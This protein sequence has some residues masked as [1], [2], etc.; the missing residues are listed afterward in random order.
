M[1]APAQVKSE[2][3]RRGRNRLTLALTLAGFLVLFG[4]PIC[5]RLFVLEAFKTP[6]GS[7]TP[8]L[9]P[10]DH[11]FVRKLALHARQRTRGEVIVFEYPENRAQDF[12]KRVIAVPGDTFT[13]KDG[14][15]W[16]NGWEVP[17]CS[18]G[19]ASYDDDNDGLGMAPSKHTGELVLE[20]LEGD[21]YLTF[22]DH[23]SGAAPHEVQGPYTVAPGEV[24]VLG[25]NR[26]NSHD[27]RM[28]W[29]SKGGG[30]PFA[31]V[32]GS[33]LVRWFPFSRAGNVSTPTLPESMKSLEPALERCLAGRPPPDKTVPPAQR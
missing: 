23:S 14:H 10:G 21:A 13:V 4:V 5:L 24:W 11:V 22:L 2:Q 17:H 18:L 20:Y 31:L 7:M 12:I 26:M 28:W 29:S 32:R 30:V 9:I 3:T 6:S 15:P 27:S 33:A 25:D 19:E 16:I 1:T 8:T